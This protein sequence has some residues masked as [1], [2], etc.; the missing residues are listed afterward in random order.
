MARQSASPFNPK[1]DNLF[2]IAYAIPYAID[3]TTTAT[4]EIGVINETAVLCG[5]V[6][7]RKLSDTGVEFAFDTLR[8]ETAGMWRVKI[9]VMKMSHEDGEVICCGSVLI[10]RIFHVE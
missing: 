2:A 6:V 5:N 7:S 10:R 9:I 8:I 4:N 3:A 1:S